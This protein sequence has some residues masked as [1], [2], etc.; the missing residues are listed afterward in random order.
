MGSYLGLGVSTSIASP[1]D[2]GVVGGSGPKLQGYG[3][4]ACLTDVSFALFEPSHID[5]GPE[6]CTTGTMVEK[7]ALLQDGIIPLK[8]S[9]FL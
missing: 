9:P 1:V 6:V 8:W 7:G 2:S 4:G 3:S 5:T